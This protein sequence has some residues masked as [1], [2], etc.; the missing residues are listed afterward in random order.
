MKKHQSSDQEL[1]GIPG[2]EQ[3]AAPKL[4]ADRAA[5]MWPD[6]PYIGGSLALLPFRTPHNY[7]QEIPKISEMPSA[8]VPDQ[9]LSIPEI[10]QRFAQGRPMTATTNLTYT[11][12]EY[13]PEV[14][15]MDL[16]DLDELKEKNQQEINRLKNELKE[17]AKAQAAAQK[18]ADEKKPDTQA[19]EQSDEGGQKKEA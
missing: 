17:L 13:A 18:K 9:T 5:E 6:W 1:T 7:K 2:A 10:L 12:D 4:S 16:V 8:T 15:G 3:S 19:T 14:R 11:G